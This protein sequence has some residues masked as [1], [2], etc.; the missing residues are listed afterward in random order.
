M[1]MHAKDGLQT[2]QTLQICFSSVFQLHENIFA[3]D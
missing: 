3:D 1:N 2:L